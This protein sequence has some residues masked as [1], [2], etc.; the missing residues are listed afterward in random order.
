MLP[1]L[2]PVRRNHRIEGIHIKLDIKL[3]DIAVAIP[4]DPIGDM[5][6]IKNGLNAINS[7]GLSDIAA[8]FICASKGLTLWHK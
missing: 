1:G 7:L 4:I 2:Y 3:A 6:I 8:Y 5:H